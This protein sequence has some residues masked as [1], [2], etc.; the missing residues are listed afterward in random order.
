VINPQLA[1]VAVGELLLAEID[2]EV[3]PVYVNGEVPT[4]VPTPPGDN[5]VK[6]YAVLFSGAGAAGPHSLAAYP[7]VTALPFQVTVAG[8]TKDRTLNGVTLIRNVLA[9]VELDGFGLIT[10]QEFD[11]GPVRRDDV[12]VPPRHF[13]PMQFVLEP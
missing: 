4:E 11:T 10:E 9:S 1:F 12:P 8:G 5:R 13:V 2:Q 3:M 6:A 7:L